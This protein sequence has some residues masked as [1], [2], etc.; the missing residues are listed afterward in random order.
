MVEDIKPKVRGAGAYGPVGYISHG[1][2]VALGV[3]ATAMGWGLL[4][5]SSF[6]PRNQLYLGH[7][8]KHVVGAGRLAQL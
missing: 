8:G 1:A 4:A 6:G 7:P 5:A 2:I 3:P